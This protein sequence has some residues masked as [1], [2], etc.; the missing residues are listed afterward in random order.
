VQELAFEY[1]DAP[2]GRLGSKRTTMPESPPLLD[3]ALP[4]TA[5]IVDAVKRSFQAFEDEAGG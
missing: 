3:R 5:D 4:S 2:V 1:L